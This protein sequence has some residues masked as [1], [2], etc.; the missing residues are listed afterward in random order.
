MTKDAREE[1]V[2]LLMDGLLKTFQ[3]A[4][5]LYIEATYLAERGSLPRAVLLHQISLEE[6]GKAE[7]LCTAIFSALHGTV[8]DM[9]QLKRAFSRHEGKNRTN[10]YFLPSSVQ[11]SEART[12]NDIEAASKAFEDMQSQFHKESNTLKNASLYVDF[13][14]K[15]VSPHD[16][17]TRENLE[18]VRKRNAEFLSLTHHKLSVAEG[19]GKDLD[20]AV[21]QQT[22]LMKELGLDGLDHTNPNERRAAANGILG[23]IEEFFKS[24]QQPSDKANP[25]GK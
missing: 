24:I 8:V 17:V 18:E 2:R 5:E 20:A 13:D 11:E 23:K 15:F 3:N 25:D 6:C 10:A 21:E 16:V 1:Q 9:R 7:M 22:L 19:W 14:G 12:N 4:E